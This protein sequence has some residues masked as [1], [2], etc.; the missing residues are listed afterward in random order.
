MAWS[1]PCC[2]TSEDR[3]RLLVAERAS[4]LAQDADD[5]RRLLYVATWD[6]QAAYQ[7]YLT[8]PDTPA[9]DERKLQVTPRYFE[10]LRTFEVLFGTGTALACVLFEGTLEQAADREAMI[11]DYA[12]QRDHYAAGVVRY[13]IGREIDQPGKSPAR[14]A[15]QDRRAVRP[16]AHG[17]LAHGDAQTRGTRLHPSSVLRPDAPGVGP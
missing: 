11:L 2:A 10:P 14:D 16:S 12:A 6:S 13:A 4:T 1:A 8:K 9:A 17:R 5:P 15:V 7:S 3:A